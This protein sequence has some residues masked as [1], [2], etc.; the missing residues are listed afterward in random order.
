MYIYHAQN[1]IIIK[2]VYNLL[3]T[4]MGCKVVRIISNKTLTTTCNKFCS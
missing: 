4:F 2:Y 3:L 1:G